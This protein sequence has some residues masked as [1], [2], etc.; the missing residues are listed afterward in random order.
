VN[1]D[2]VSQWALQA[3]KDSEAIDY[4][5]SRG[6]TAE[7]RKR[8]KIGIR[9]RG[10]ER[11]LTIPQLDGEE[12]VNVKYR[13]LPPAEKKFMREPGCRS[14]PFNKAAL[15]NT[16][17]IFVCE[18]E[19]DTISLVQL[20]F[21]NAVGTTTGARAF[22][23][24]WL[25]LFDGQQRIYMVYDQ[26]AAGQRGAF[27]RA[28]QLGIDRVWNVKLPEGVNDVNDFVRVG[29]T[30]EQ[31]LDLV[32]SAKRYEVENIATV[33]T[34]LDELRDRIVFGPEDSE[35]DRITSSVPVLD[36]VANA[37]K[38]GAMVGITARP[39]I[40]KTTFALQT[41]LASAVAQK[42]A[43]YIC[44]EMTLQELV[45]KL[46]QATCSVEA[47]DI[48]AEEVEM[49]RKMFGD[50]PLYLAHLPRAN[51]RELGDVFNL[52]RDAI[53]RYGLKLVVFDHIHNLLRGSHDSERDATALSFEFKKLA[54]EESVVMMPLIQPRKGR[55]GSETTEQDMKYSQAFE[56]DCDLI[57][58]MNRE[59][60]S[61]PSFGDDGVTEEAMSPLTKFTITGR[62]TSG[63]SAYLM[64]EG[65]FSR[66][67]QLNAEELRQLEA[68]WRKER[69]GRG[70]RRYR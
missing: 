64:Y 36:R 1:F 21:E 44:T 30:R 34:T 35:E 13:S 63:G 66:F 51:V 26:D 7:T 53:R 48:G 57:V 31:F 15:A 29:G 3:Q 61:V 60:L 39:K 10:S 49:A 65:E 12:V 27:D 47:E 59:K 56:S 16:E 9:I 41:A 67:R 19:I 23:D 52:I 50:A 70:P 45:T 2:Q 28:R 17:E 54:L 69:S 6:I 58:I 4:L 22:P 5:E 18:G 46:V 68:A 43:L 40:G 62:F 37:M 14:V 32:Q 55:E 25:P 11:W 42:P 20:G 24:D 8:F 38:L 33:G